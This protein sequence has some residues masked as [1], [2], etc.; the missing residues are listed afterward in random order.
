MS[1]GSKRDL[2]PSP[3][4][5]ALTS[6]GGLPAHVRSGGG[7]AALD[8]L[9]D[10]EDPQAFVGEL[11]TGE[12]YFTMKEIGLGDSHV[13]I[14][15]ATPEQIQG[16]LDL[17]L[18]TGHE[19][20]LERWVNWL[21]MARSHSIDTAMKLIRS[22]EPELLQ[23]FFTRDI[24]VH[25]GDLDLDLVPDELQLVPSP[26]GAFWVTIS[27]DH[28][29]SDFLHDMLK[30]MWATDMDKMRDIF[31]T[32][33]FDLESSIEESLIRFRQGRLEE[34]GFFTP[35]EALS[36]YAYSSPQKVRD[37]VRKNLA[38]MRVAPPLKHGDVMHDVVLHHVTPPDALGA[39]LLDMLPTERARFAET[40][41]YLV[42]KVFMARTGDLS[43]TDALPEIGGHCGALVNLG[44]LWLAD[45]SLP[46]AS[47]V[48]QS[49]WP[50]QL[51]RVG[52]SLVT[53]LSRQARRL[54]T[55]SGAHQN[56]RLFGEPVDDVLEGLS[57][58]HPVLY[59]G[60]VSPGTLVWR[61][62]RTLE[63]LSRLEIAL[64]DATS[65]LDFFEDHLGF[66]PEALMGASF[67]DLPESE[68]DGITFATLFRTGVAQSMLTDTF[69]FE[70]LSRDEL[71]AFLSVAF[72]LSAGRVVP[73]AELNVVLGPLKTQVGDLMG[74]WID[75]QVDELGSALGRV[76]AYD[77]DPAFASALILTVGD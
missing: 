58:R 73:T 27:R 23:L 26:D 4:L 49:L 45:E 13:L 56:L 17:D 39:V 52:F 72:D 70:P 6:R 41:T 47:Q 77:L 46:R 68:R 11:A 35:G 32:V 55:R 62:V 1:N 18:W 28:E 31:Q 29:L 69:T 64:A 21:D 40:F 9:L 14:E 65:V 51:F 48:A 67:G 53:D 34:M 43:Q 8:W 63:E 61:D 42:N 30:L 24:T 54:S 75:D 57:R 66:S 33:R 44:L 5:A 71:A 37:E 7:M 25:P 59:E 3:S 60:L 10:R 36:V 38:A 15:L 16:I 20:K 12:L 19:I 22:T 76:Q 2:P 74:A 50:E